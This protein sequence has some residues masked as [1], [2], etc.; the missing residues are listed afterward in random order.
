[1]DDL[2]LEEVRHQDPEQQDHETAIDP[3]LEISGMA[4]GEAS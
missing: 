4:H 1:M 3:H 2:H